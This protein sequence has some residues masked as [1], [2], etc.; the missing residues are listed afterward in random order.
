LGKGTQ[1][2]TRFYQLHAISESSVSEAI[3][4]R[5][6]ESVAIALSVGNFPDYLTRSQIVTRSSDNKLQL[7]PFDHWA[8]PIGVN[9][10]R[11]L[12]I[13]L[14]VQLATDRIYYFPWKKSR[15]VDYEVL[16]DVARFDGELGGDVVL[17]ARWSIFDARGREELVTESARVTVPAETEDYEAQVAAM[18]RAVGEFSRNIAASIKNLHQGGSG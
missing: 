15:S 9:F 2:S 17:I 6:D 8:E 14:S 10:G 4:K 18:S 1:E 11:V 12:L 13:D 7:A 16:V 3:F 5:G